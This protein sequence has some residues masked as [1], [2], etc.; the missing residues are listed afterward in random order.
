[1]QNRHEST[2]LTCSKISSLYH[3]ICIAL[4][5]SV[6]IC[7]QSI[8]SV[9]AIESGHAIRIV[10]DNIPDS[11]VASAYTSHMFRLDGAGKDNVSN[12]K[13]QFYLPSVN[14]VETL[15]KSA[16]GCM[17]F[18]IDAVSEPDN[19]AVS[20]DGE[21]SG[22][23]VFSGVLDGTA[24]NLQYNVTLELR[25]SI[26]EVS[27]DRR[28]NGDSYDAICEV[29]YKGADYLYVTLE[30]EYGSTLRSLFVRE[31]GQAH[32]VY[33]NITS[34]YYAW[35]VIKAENQY[36]S[37]VYTVELPPCGDAV[38]LPGIGPA[39]DGMSGNGCRIAVH[40]NTL[41]LEGCTDTDVVTEI[42]SAD[43]VL[44]SRSFSS[45]KTDLGGLCRGTYIV[46][47]I[48]NDRVI[49]KKIVRL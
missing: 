46:R 34:S 24:V 5:M 14:G 25:P 40:G 10:G 4:F 2:V 48:L 45:A 41:V 22:K 8:L 33:G 49:T 3:F 31:P 9:E 44:V 20:V 47:I 30:E 16:E 6:W 42:Y 26:L 19:H 15:Q 23:I 39:T 11:G 35:I 29:G 38:G 1:M 43:G 21:I 32:F 18:G 17:S 13:W 12:A 36:G 27:V 7:P 28:K 37:D